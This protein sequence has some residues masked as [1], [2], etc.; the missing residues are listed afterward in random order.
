[1]KQNGEAVGSMLI[2]CI[3]VTTT[4]DS[5]KQNKSVRSGPDQDEV[6]EARRYRSLGDSNS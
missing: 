1:M 2:K 4:W 3:C 6:N 5:K